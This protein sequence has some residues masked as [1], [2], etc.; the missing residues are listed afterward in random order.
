MKGLTVMVLCI[1][2]LCILVSCENATTGLKTDKDATANTDT[3]TDS[4]SIAQND[5]ILND[6]IQNDDPLS[7]DL[8]PDGVTPD[9]PTPDGPQND[10]Q[11]PDGTL[12]DNPQND[13]VVTPDA[14]IPAATCDGFTC[15]DVNSHC[16]VVEN[17]PTC[18]C[19]EG[20]HWN[21]GI[22]VED[23]LTETGTFS[24]TFTGPVNAEGTGTTS[25]QGGEGSVTFSHLGAD[26]TYEK[27]TMF[28][29]DISPVATTQGTNILVT[30]TSEFSF[31]G[32]QF[33]SFLIPAD[34]IV[35]G[36]HSFSTA[37]A[38]VSYGDMTFSG[39]NL[40]IDCVRAMSNDGTF[41][42]G[43]VTAGQLD[44]TAA[45]GKM[46]DPAVLGSNLP[47]PICEE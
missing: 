21:T 41:T 2:A 24:F 46:Y 22:C 32:T 30:W 13:T 16:E 19:D 10:N 25:L 12:P 34:Q 17:E 3:A 6:G 5:D 36:E 29:R 18:L 20:Y 42:I 37:K 45:S 23:T 14:D 33:F 15:E 27:Q 11:Q 7:D 39:G 47:Y 4:D 28:G 35:A 1:M 38:V 8:L 43:T 9:D 44:I 31:S 26:I 40:A